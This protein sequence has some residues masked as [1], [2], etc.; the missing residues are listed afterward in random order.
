[1]SETRP[2][3]A[4]KSEQPVTPPQAGEPAVRPE[5]ATAPKLQSLALIVALGALALSGWQLYDSQREIASLRHALTR[6]NAATAVKT[7]NEQLRATDGRLTLA[8]ARLAEANGQFA[9][10]NG[11]YQDMSKVRSDWLL[12]EVGHTLALA[13]QELQLAGNVPTAI[14]SL[15]AVDARLATF[16]RPELIGVKKAVAQDLE[17]L[18]AL[19]FLDTIGLTARID[20]LT[21][22]VDALPLSLDIRREQQ[23]A[24]PTR[25]DAPF[26]SRLVHDISQSLGEMVRIRRLDNPDAV[27]MT[28]EQA[29]QLRENIKL[30]L[31]DARVALL[32]RRGAP[33]TADMV[34]VQR[35][36]DLY[37]DRNAPATRQWL[38]LLAEL[39]AA[40]INSALP[41]LSDSLKAVNKA[42]AAPGG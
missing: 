39:K 33:Y 29:F 7:L 16:D 30:R 28:P 6:Q 15:Q 35:Y 38:A 5:P 18:K 26:W 13:S 21:Q 12:S 32:Q 42:Q 14:S 2:L 23:P 8:E 36:I 22:S 24:R 34:A 41:D 17:R 3:D 19:P 9:T 10:L 11:M 37:F 4:E 40:P 20:S 27:L 31:L 25:S 1:M